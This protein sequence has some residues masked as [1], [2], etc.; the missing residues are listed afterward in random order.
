M[1]ALEPTCRM[2]AAITTYHLGQMQSS[3]LISLCLSFLIHIMDIVILPSIIHLRRANGKCL[4]Q[5]LKHSHWLNKCPYYYLPSETMISTVRRPHIIV[6]VMSILPRSPRHSPLPCMLAAS[7]SKSQPLSLPEGFLWSPESDQTTHRA[8]WLVAL[9]AA[10][11]KWQWGAVYI[12]LI[13]LALQVGQ[14]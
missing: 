4:I 1:R 14:V 2:T 13:F 6:E 8:G 9:G 12:C 3:Y 11:T 10:L 7:E 5:C